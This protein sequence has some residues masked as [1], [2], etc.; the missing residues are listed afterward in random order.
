MTLLVATLDD[1]DGDILL[2]NLFVSVE[3]SIH[4]LRRCCP[5]LIRSTRTST[6]ASTLQGLS[7]VVQLIFQCLLE[8]LLLHVL[9]DGDDFAGFALTTPHAPTARW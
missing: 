7:I 6:S 9:R 4:K 8:P 1:A 3:G 2:L 5:T